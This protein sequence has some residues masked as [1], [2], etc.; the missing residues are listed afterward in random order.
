M[1]PRESARDGG[2]EAAEAAFSTRGFPSR[3][4]SVTF[5]QTRPPHDRVGSEPLLRFGE[6]AP[7]VVAQPR[8]R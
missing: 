2:G 5:E 3:R 7:L 1:P 6:E 8:L 4:P